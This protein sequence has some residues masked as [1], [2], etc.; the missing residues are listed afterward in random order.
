MT[1]LAGL[2]A[3]GASPLNAV[4]TRR[5][6]YADVSHLVVLLLLGVA[7][8]S[9]VHAL[10]TSIAMTTTFRY[11]SFLVLFAVVSQP[12]GDHR[13]QRRDR[14]GARHRRGDRGA[15]AL[16][17]FLAGHEPVATLKGTQ[18]DDMGF[19]LATTHPAGPLAPG[20]ASWFGRS[21]S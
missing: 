6:I 10:D 17:N 19:L 2:L 20:F 16:N 13:L 11:A 1:K 21:S 7:L 3:F 15:I 5:R 4:V 12:G 8:L 18:E 14:V 9:T